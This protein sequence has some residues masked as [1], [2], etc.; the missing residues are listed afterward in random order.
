MNKIKLG[1]IGLGNMGTGHAGNITNGNCPDITLTAVADINPERIT[2]G[3]E[4]LNGE[5]T[6]FD[7]AIAMLDSRLIDACIIS[8]PHYDHPKYAIECMKRGIH[9]KVS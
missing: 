3:K 8:V 6:Y 5:I 2:W 1:I 9:V 7:D 4:N